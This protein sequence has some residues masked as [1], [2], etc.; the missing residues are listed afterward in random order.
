VA[1]AAERGPAGGDES[2]VE[3]AASDP[4]FDGH[5]PQHPVLPGVVLL[6]HVLAAARRRL[7]PRAWL[8]GI[9]SLRWRQPVRPGDVLAIRLSTG[10]AGE[11]A[12]EVRRHDGL[13]ANGSL[14][15][16]DGAA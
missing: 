1:S 10:A 9:A 3:I 13:V 6:D 16:R 7:G 2:R 15:V 12:F 4:A 8:A 5:F 14:R 11:I